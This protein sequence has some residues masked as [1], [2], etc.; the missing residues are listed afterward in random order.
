MTTLPRGLTFAHARLARELSTPTLRALYVRRAI[1]VCTDAQD[2][3]R[4]VTAL[5]VVNDVAAFRSALDVALAWLALGLECASLDFGPGAGIH[6]ESM[7][8]LRER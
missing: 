7:K 4:L 5:R 6:F 1:R 2:R 3:E 8:S